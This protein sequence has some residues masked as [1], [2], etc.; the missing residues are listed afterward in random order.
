[1]TIQNT[2]KSDLQ[3]HLVCEGNRFV[4]GVGAASCRIRW[5]TRWLSI[6]RGYDEDGDIAEFVN[7]AMPPVGTPIPVLNAADRPTTADG[8]L[9]NRW[10]T[11]YYDPAPSGDINQGSFLIVGYTQQFI[12]GD[13]WVWIAKY[14]GSQHVEWADRQHDNGSFGPDDFWRRATNTADVISDAQLPANAAGV[15]YQED[16]HHQGKVSIGAGQRFGGGGA[17]ESWRVPVAL[18]DVNRWNQLR[19]GTD[20]RNAED[21]IYATGNITAGTSTVSDPWV[22]WPVA[23]N[24]KSFIGHL[25]QTAGFAFGWGA[26]HQVGETTHPFVLATSGTGGQ[27]GQHWNGIAAGTQAQTWRNRVSTPSSGI[28]WQ[29]VYSAGDPGTQIGQ[30]SFFKHFAPAANLNG[31]RYEWW[32]RDRNGTLGL[33]HR[34]VPSRFS[35]NAYRDVINPNNVADDAFLV[36]WGDPESASGQM[37]L[38]VRNAELSYFNGAVN[39]AHRFYGPQ[40]RPAGQAILSLIEDGAGRSRARF[41][42][43]LPSGASQP[44]GLASGDLWR[45]T[46]D[47]SVRIV[48]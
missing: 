18:L 8:I 7:I 12:Q 13:S 17:D 21:V 33:A 47:N 34:F 46:G 5:G 31:Y 35:N 36:V 30:F 43:G 37:S 19:T 26:I 29:E 4:T 41:E 48:P 10:E 15:D 6:G 22:G 45:H 40:T 2:A 39:R 25:N 42:L 14:V 23:A 11:L 3:R 1:M 44:A 9:L 28:G 20:R 38:G 24:A 32:S 27:F 16:I